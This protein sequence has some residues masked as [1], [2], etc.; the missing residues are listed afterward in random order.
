MTDLALITGSAVGIGAAFAERLAKEG[1]RLALV[2]RDEGPF[3]ETRRRL[4]E[5]GATVE[6]L[7]ADLAKAADL[8]RVEAYIVEHEDLAVLINNA[9]FADSRPFLRL[10]SERIDEMIAVHT[11]AP[12]RLARAALPG[13]LAR[14]RGALIT[15][16]SPAAFN[17]APS[18][19]WVVYCAC[20]AF[21]L[22]LSLGL[23]E[24]VKGTGV[25]AMALCPGWVQTGI[26]QHGGFDWPVPEASMSPATL[27]DLALAALA[28]GETVCLPSVEDVGLF[29]SYLQIQRTLF[30]EALSHGEPASRYRRP[31]ERE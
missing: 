20:K 21:A 10:P 25:R 15:M 28:A 31:E 16:A 5:A 29:E 24:Q 6:T 9:G 19:A 11:I 30:V 26:L 22:S 23:A 2:D 27:V 18:A 13:M 1:F 17:T 4:T 8:R 14:D 3:E 12:A 7:V